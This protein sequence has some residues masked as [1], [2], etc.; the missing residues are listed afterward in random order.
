M[1]SELQ[2]SVRTLREGYRNAQHG[3]RR[4]SFIVECGKLLAQQDLDRA[5][6]GLLSACS[7]SF[8]ATEAGLMRY[9]GGRLTVV[10][11]SGALP[12]PGARLAPRGGLSAM[13]KWPARP[14]LREQ[15]T[16]PWMCLHA[17]MAW[18]LLLALSAR[19]SVTGLLV[20]AARHGPA[21]D[22]EDM[23]LLEA[24]GGLL[25]GHWAQ[26]MAAS[27]PEPCR[28][29]LALLTPREVEVL[30][31][32][33]RGYSN[34]RIGEALGMATGT[35]KIHVERILRKLQLEDRAQ[36]A[37]RAVEWNLGTSE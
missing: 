25:G 2:T 16:E 32:L 18:E 10:A 22:A 4:R 15:L 37:A 13:L 23:A 19:A 31:L 29:T 28:T 35:A 26:A 11:S 12:P 9:Q 1:P 8:A 6:S 27:K 33:P 30:S 20:L 5:S 24:F 7:R 34:A 17:P 3:L 36:A 14:L 21:P